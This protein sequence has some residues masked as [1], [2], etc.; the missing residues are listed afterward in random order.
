MFRIK[1]GV[2]PKLYSAPT[3]THVFALQ[4]KVTDF[5]YLCESFLLDLFKPLYNSMCVFQLFGVWYDDRYWSNILFCTNPPM[6]MTYRSR[7]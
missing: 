3:P 6:R 4:I 2:C 1:I 7:S 5:D